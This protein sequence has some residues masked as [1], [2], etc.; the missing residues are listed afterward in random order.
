MKTI[1][2]ILKTILK[3]N[4]AIKNDVFWELKRE[5]INIIEDEKDVDED[6]IEKLKY[7]ID[8]I[9]NIP[10][11]SKIVFSIYINK[12]NE[13]DLKNI[14]K[15]KSELN[16]LIINEIYNGIHYNVSGEKL[17]KVIKKLELSVALSKKQRVIENKLSNLTKIHI[18]HNFDYT[19]NIIQVKFEN[20]K[21]EETLLYIMNF[22]N[23]Y[24]FYELKYDIYDL[25]KH[26]KLNFHKRYISTNKYKVL[27]IIN[28]N[29]ISIDN[30]TTAYYRIL[31][32]SLAY[33]ISEGKVLLPQYLDASI[34]NI[35]IDSKQLFD[36]KYYKN[37]ESKLDLYNKNKLYK[38]ENIENLLYKINIAKTEDE[39]FNLI[40][41]AGNIINIEKNID[42]YIY[43]ISKCYKLN[44]NSIKIALFCEDLINKKAI[45]AS[46]IISYLMM[47]YNNGI[48]TKNTLRTIKYMETVYNDTYL[49][50]E[51][52]LKI[53]FKESGI[54]Q[55]FIDE[56]LGIYNKSK[57]KQNL[58]FYLNR[59]INEY[60][61]E[62]NKE[63]IR[64]VYEFYEKYKDIRAL[65]RICKYMYEND[66]DLM[67]MDLSQNN[68]LQ[69][70]EFYKKQDKKQ[71]IMYMLFIM[72]HCKKL[73]KK[74]ISLL[75]SIY[76]NKDVK[77]SN[78][79]F[80]YLILYKDKDEIIYK[81]YIE[82]LADLPVEQLDETTVEEVKELFLK[83]KLNNIQLATVKFI[84][85]YY[86]LND[87]KI[88]IK[89]IEKYLQEYSNLDQYN[90][91][92]D[93]L[94][95]QI[96]NI[97]F[98]QD[99]L[100]YINF[101]NIDNIYFILDLI[102]KEL[103][104]N[105]EYNLIS[106]ILKCYDYNKDYNK[107][108][109]IVIAYVKF[110]KFID[111]LEYD[112]IIDDM[113][114]NLDEDEKKKL[115]NLLINREDFPI[116]IR[117][118]YYDL[119]P[120]NLNNNIIIEEFNNKNENIAVTILEKYLVLVK[121]FEDDEKFLDIVDR[122]VIEDEFEDSKYKQLIEETIY[123]KIKI[124]FK[125][126]KEYV[127]DLLYKVKE[128][129]DKLKEIEEY[130]DI[131]T[132]N[133]IEDFHDIYGEYKVISRIEGD[134]CNKLDIEHIFNKDQ[135]KVLVFKDY[136]TKEIILNYLKT[137]NIEYK[138]YESN[139]YADPIYLYTI[140]IKNSIP[141]TKENSLMNMIQNLV[142]LSK[143][144]QQ[145][146]RKNKMIKT[147]T[148]DSFIYTNKGFVVADFID[149][150]EF[151]INS[152]TKDLS[153]EYDLYKLDKKGKYY[154]LN[155]KNITII[156][157]K[158][159]SM[160]LDNFCNESEDI[161]FIHKFNLNIIENENINNIDSLIENMISFITNENKTIEELT[162]KQKLKGFHD[163]D[164]TEQKSLMDKIINRNDMT[165][166]A[167]KIIIYNYS[168]EFKINYFKYLLNCINNYNDG[169][170][171]VDLLEIYEK[172]DSTVNDALLT[173]ENDIDTEIENMYLNICNKTSLL[174]GDIQ[175]AVMKTNL[176]IENKNYVTRRLE[177]M[178]VKVTNN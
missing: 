74:T 42:V 46:D 37:L 108:Y 57:N 83:D 15:M 76:N 93:I 170:N 114:K 167:K 131:Y 27:Y 38:V 142:E 62:F 81:Y 73:E 176:S 34:K 112:T 45:F 174:L 13:E 24:Y 175:K 14:K 132:N 113:L 125:D 87:T 9:K 6:W 12:F 153:E 40:N 72:S 139:D 110:A 86:I 49:F 84:I 67:E 75:K 123:K 137:L 47:I 18:K 60:K 168:N 77:N 39:I 65:D 48:Y 127:E 22:E 10:I 58:D 146:I 111:E 51:L 169:L 159:I 177:N 178:K 134:V 161:K 59:I 133:F 70:I 91:F 36:Y 118:R 8:Y 135:S 165:P 154:V 33:E 121:Y 94:I 30:Y 97:R 55:E 163:I 124:K 103:I 2:A 152:L 56:F 96:K 158:Y 28:D 53:K 156:L 11:E 148:K 149:I 130:I 44:K 145:L 71:N 21:L 172:L 115:Y 43:A 104:N 63:S 119:N 23:Y 105:E 88:A 95:Q 116:E 160:I 109:N 41:S 126:D 26:I 1:K 100:K 136:Y 106:E 151:N 16:D 102:A 147:F 166:E 69:L 79:L 64:M 4:Y 3:N 68:L 54:S 29:G 157:K 32:Y 82:K 144:Q 78:K 50:D 143:L 61:I 138:I 7:T 35:L 117:E 99:I 80:N 107:A 90:L 120:S 141:Y 162:Y 52:K 25:F 155:Q 31:S 150:I 20:I 19:E 89:C 85:D 66:R 98:I 122:K 171:E 92:R 164:E 5:S 173:D 17:Y 128:K 129:N 101:N 140:D